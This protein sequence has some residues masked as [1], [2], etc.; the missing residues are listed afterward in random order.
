MALLISAA[1]PSLLGPV[2]PMILH[3]LPPL[4]LLQLERINAADIHL[5]VRITSLSSLTL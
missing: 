1:L 3:R 4:I 5:E 2:F